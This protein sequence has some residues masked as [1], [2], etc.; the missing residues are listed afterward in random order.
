MK[1][2]VFLAG[3]VALALAGCAGQGGVPVPTL[4]LAQAQGYAVAL[5]AAADAAIVAVEPQLTGQTLLNVSHAK[6]VLDA[7][8]GTFTATPTQP[9]LAALVSVAQG[10]VPLI[11]GLSATDQGLIDAALAGL[12]AFAANWHPTPVPVVPPVPAPASAHR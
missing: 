8:V 7:A 1:T 10:L 5:Q 11:P 6:G 3:A 2:K 9:N 12:Q 4:T